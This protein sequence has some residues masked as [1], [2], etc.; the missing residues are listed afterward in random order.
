MPESR[1]INPI[2]ARDI[3]NRIAGELD[4][5][6]WRYRTCKPGS[7]KDMRRIGSLQKAGRIWAAIAPMITEIFFDVSLER[8]CN[9]KQAS[10][11]LWEAPCPVH[12]V[13]RG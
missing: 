1:K 7:T 3:V 8:E 9:C 5:E 11:R 13:K 6:A 10:E 2:R 12:G 4:K